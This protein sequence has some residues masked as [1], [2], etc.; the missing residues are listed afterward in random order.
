MA[1]PDAEVLAERENLLQ[2][3]TE[4]AATPSKFS[5]IFLGQD[6]FD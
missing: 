3:I 2:Q 5:E 6:V 4:C 1:R